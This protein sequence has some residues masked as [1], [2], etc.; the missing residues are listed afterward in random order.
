[1]RHNKTCLKV[2]KQ[3]NK[4]FVGDAAIKDSIYE[5]NEKKQELIALKNKRNV[6]E[7]IKEKAEVASEKIDAL[8]KEVKAETP[9]IDA[10]LAGT[11]F[12]KKEIEAIRKTLDAVYELYG[13]CQD[14]NTL[15]DRVL[16]KLKRK[17]Q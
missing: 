4:G 11:Q 16:K 12:T 2:N 3:Q 6:S 5:L 1:M 13:S 7:P 8:P 9:N 14:R 15:V 17:N 10:S